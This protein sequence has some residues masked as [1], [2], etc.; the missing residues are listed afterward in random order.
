[1]GLLSLG[2]SQM[3]QLIVDFN[4]VNENDAAIV[5]SVHNSSLN[6][7]TGLLGFSDSIDGK[8][9][10]GQGR[11]GVFGQGGDFGMFGTG[12]LRAAYFWG[13]LEYTG[14]LVG[15]VSDSKFKSILPDDL[16]A[17]S[18]INKLFPR[19]YEYKFSEFPEM[20]FSSGIHNGFVAQE[21]ENVFPHLVHES[22]RPAV[23]ATDGS[24]LKG[25]QNYKSINYL[26]LIPILTKG[27][28]ELHQIIE[29]QQFLIEK[30]NSEIEKLKSVVDLI[31]KG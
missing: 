3:Q 8:G 2:F 25:E 18:S 30:Q 28:Q 21:L 23:Y 12:N 27:I 19:I 20:N 22:I 7:T 1:M 11:T 26:E 5:S 4:A 31:Q 10:T 29:S 16:N 6:S 9:V 17:L 15:P 14:S 24:L 13:D